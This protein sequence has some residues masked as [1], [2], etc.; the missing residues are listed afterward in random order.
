MDVT[1]TVALITGARRLGAVVATEL[2]KAGA[3]IALVYHTSRDAALATAATV[4]ASGRRALTIKADLRMPDDCT[5]AVDEAAASLGR[6]DILVN[7]ASV[8][9]A[10]PDEH[11]TVADWDDQLDVDVRAAWLCS[12]AALPHMARSGGGRIINFSDWTARSGRPRVKGY[13]A[14]H[15]AKTAV[16]GLT[17]ALALELAADQILVNAIAPGPVLPP[18]ERPAGQRAEDERNTPVRGGPG[19]LEVAKAVLALIRS[20]AITGETIRIDGGRHVT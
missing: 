17:E 7:M 9:S 5:R 11:P 6:L 4:T 16:I 19:P 15:T 8:Y 13:V 12:R 18:D 3:D 10:T 2:A 1:G 14:Y 20:D